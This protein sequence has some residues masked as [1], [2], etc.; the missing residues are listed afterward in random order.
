M[1]RFSA[2]LF[3]LATFVGCQTPTPAMATVRSA[4]LEGDG[5]VLVGIDGERLFPGYLGL[6]SATIPSPFSRESLTRV[7]FVEGL[8]VWH[9]H[10]SERS[11]V[12]RDYDWGPTSSVSW[13][14]RNQEGRW[15]EKYVVTFP[16]RVADILELA[17]GHILVLKETIEGETIVE[18]WLLDPPY[19]PKRNTQ[20]W[21]TAQGAASARVPVG[22]MHWKGPHENPNPDLNAL[23]TELLRMDLGGSPEVVCTAGG[24]RFLI[25]LTRNRKTQRVLLH[26][27]DLK[28][29]AQHSILETSDNQRMLATCTELSV[30]ESVKTGGFTLRAHGMGELQDSKRRVVEVLSRGLYLSGSSN[31]GIEKGT[32]VLLDPTNPRTLKQITVD[33]SFEVLPILGVGSLRGQL[34]AE[35]GDTRVYLDIEAEEREMEPVIEGGVVVVDTPATSQAGDSA[36]LE[37]NMMRWTLERTKLSNGTGESEC[38]ESR[39]EFEVDYRIR[40][41]VKVGNGEFLILG[42]GGVRRPNRFSP[43]TRIDYWVV[44]YPYGPGLT[45]SL[46]LPMELG[47]EYRKPT[48]SMGFPAGR[49]SFHDR[50][51]DLIQLPRIES[52]AGGRSASGAGDYLPVYRQKTYVWSLQRSPVALTAFVPGGLVFVLTR[53]PKTKGTTLHKLEPGK[54]WLETIVTSSLQHPILAAS[55]EVEVLP[56]GGSSGYL[57]AVWGVGFGRLVDSKAENHWVRQ[58]LCFGDLN[59]DGEFEFE[60]VFPDR[61]ALHQYHL[62]LEGKR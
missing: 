38:A 35:S 13:T 50:S 52:A 33:P 48:T 31:L 24:G 9:V 32:P 15:L 44:D 34:I 16:L 56:V 39:F 17:G 37:E 46:W 41:G 10:P 5:S 27:F 22:T 19:G 20:E 7:D 25:L 3:I 54:D 58:V 49:L 59:G 29:G 62:M 23:R 14:T 1:I 40:G 61:G 18:S 6:C 42:D 51:C 60:Q 57:L 21:F 4:E 43:R 2:V 8:W 45:D 53:D 47:E 28:E 30:I 11:R 26:Q 36:N 12:A 55:V